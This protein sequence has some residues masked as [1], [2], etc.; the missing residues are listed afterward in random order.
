MEEKTIYRKKDELGR[1]H[2]AHDFGYWYITA[3]TEDDYDA[4]DVYM[5]AKTHPDR[6]Y[7]VEVK[8]YTNSDYERPYSKFTWNGKDYGYQIDFEKTD[9]LL[10]KWVEEG[11][12]PIVYARFSDITL[13]WDLRFISVDQRKKQVWTNAD[14]QHYG[15]K[16]ELTWQT[17]LY[18]SE[19]VWEKTT[20]KI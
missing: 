5:T 15:E 2:F 18:R 9:K 3:G 7:S 16:K 20:E 6:T 1:T 12:I 17:Y 14:G 13:V 8:D 4:V 19:A 11:R 10:R